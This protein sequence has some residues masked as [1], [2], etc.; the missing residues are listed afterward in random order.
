MDSH[1]RRKCVC[2]VHLR[3]LK[4]Q[5]EF[6]RARR[7]MIPKRVV[8]VKQ[9]VNVS[10]R[11]IETPRP[12]R[13]RAA[14]WTRTRTFRGTICARV[15]RKMRRR[16]ARIHRR[17]VFVCLDTM[18][19]MKACAFH[20]VSVATKEMLA[21]IRAYSVQIHIIQHSKL[22]APRSSSACACPDTSP[23]LCRIHAKRAI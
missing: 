12:T 17:L 9:G 5:K 22:E 2:R 18:A 11:D 19:R 13:A 10:R 15:A 14:P 8:S 23:V 3:L 6:K 4:T 1:C 7:A 20:V 21:I 16:M